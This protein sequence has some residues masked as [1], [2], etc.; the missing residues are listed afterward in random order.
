MC[1]LKQEF[2]DGW[3]VQINQFQKKKHHGVWVLFATTEKKHCV[4]P[5]VMHTPPPAFLK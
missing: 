1:Q 2:P 3:V 4:V 5:K